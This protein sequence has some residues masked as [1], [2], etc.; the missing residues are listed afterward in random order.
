MRLTKIAMSSWHSEIAAGISLQLPRRLRAMI[1]SQTMVS[2][3][4]FREIFII[5]N[6]VFAGLCALSFAIIWRWRGSRPDS[7]VCD[8]VACFG[9]WQSLN[10]ADDDNRKINPSFLPYLRCHDKPIKIQNSSLGT[11]QSEG[12]RNYFFM[13]DFLKLA[14]M[15]G[16][17]PYPSWNTISQPTGTWSSPP[18]GR[19]RLRI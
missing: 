13:W 1:L 17:A 5:M 19:V 11:R 9:I 10:N 14:P 6:E 3:S 15:W 8:G 16:I 2:R 18:A 4:F 7:W 12:C